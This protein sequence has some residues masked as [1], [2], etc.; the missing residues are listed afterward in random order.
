VSEEPHENELNQAEEIAYLQTTP[1]ETILGN[2][3]FVLIQLAALHLAS[4][5][6][7][8]TSAELVIDIVSAMVKAGGDRLGEH[9]DL[10]RSA[11]AEIQ[12]VYVRAKSAAT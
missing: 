4:T 8:L 9:A 7:N 3:L 6:A 5:P 2:Y 1:V 11:L 12:Q 10:Y